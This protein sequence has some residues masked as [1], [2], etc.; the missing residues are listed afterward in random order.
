MMMTTVLCQERVIIMMPIF[1]SVELYFTL[2][3][4]SFGYFCVCLLSS[5]SSTSEKRDSVMHA[6]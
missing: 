6:N 4:S 2:S 5:V 3:C 1:H